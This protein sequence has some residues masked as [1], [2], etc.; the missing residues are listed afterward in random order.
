MGRTTDRFSFSEWTSPR[1]RSSDTDPTHMSAPRDFPHLEGLDDVLEL[2]VVQR[3]ESDTAL[4]AL[5]GLRGVVLEPA[6][7]LDG[8]VVGDDN[9]VAQQPRLAVAADEPAADDRA[10]D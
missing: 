3:A 7:R 4:E 8:E 5:A 9:A 2:D 1:S 6:Q 10:G